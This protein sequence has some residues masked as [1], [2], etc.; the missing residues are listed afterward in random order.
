MGETGLT[1]PEDPKQI[2]DELEKV[3]GPIPE[4]STPQQINRYPIRA[5][6]L[7]DPSFTLEDIE[8]RGKEYIDYVLLNQERKDIA[9]RTRLH[10]ETS[11]DGPVTHCSID[12]LTGDFNGSYLLHPDESPNNKFRALKMFL[13]IGITDLIDVRSIAKI[14]YYEEGGGFTVQLPL[15]DMEAASQLF[16]KGMLLEPRYSIYLIGNP[17]MSRFWLNFP[18]SEKNRQTEELTEGQVFQ[19]YLWRDLE[20]MLTRS[21]GMLTFTGRQDSNYD[22]IIPEAINFNQ[23]HADMSG[24]RSQWTKIAQ[25]YPIQLFVRNNPKLMNG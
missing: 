4:F 16:N 6:S 9:K 5:Y 7:S 24:N 17:A 8:K 3:F 20:Y 1:V 13:F 25:N 19:P 23:L 15:G 18:I 11:A 22:L 21:N 10:R 12:F 14:T 2:R